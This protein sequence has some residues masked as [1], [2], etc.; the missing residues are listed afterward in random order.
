MTDLDESWIVEKILGHRINSKTKSLEWK[1]KW[2]GS[3][4]VTWENVSS[5]IGD[6]QLD[7]LKYNREKKWQLTWGH[8]RVQQP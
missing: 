6:V 8:S 3:D 7:W 5:F 4:N 2:K 1:V